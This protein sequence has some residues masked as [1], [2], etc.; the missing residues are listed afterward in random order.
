ENDKLEQFTQDLSD[1]SL[2][3]CPFVR[4]RCSSIAPIPLTSTP[5]KD[6]SL[7]SLNSPGSKGDTTIS[8][9]SS[10]SSTSTSSSSSI[11]SCSET[12]EK[13]LATQ[14]LS[15][16]T[17]D[18][19]DTTSS[20]SST[21]NMSEYIEDHFID[22]D[23]ITS[24]ERSSLE[25]TIF[26]KSNSYKPQKRLLFPGVLNRLIF[27]RRFFSESDLQRKQFSMNENENQ[28]H[29]YHSNTINEHSVEVHLINTYGSDTELHVWSHDCAE[30]RRF[31]NERQHYQH[32]EN[33]IE[34]K[35]F[36]H[37]DHQLAVE[38]QILLQQIFEY[39]WLL[40]ENDLDRTTGLSQI[41]TE[42]SL[43][44]PADNVIVP[45]HNPDFYQL[46][47]LT[48]SSSFVLSHD[49]NIKHTTASTT[50]SFV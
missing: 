1:G 31:L 28:F 22:Q 3:L 50:S 30:Q 11:F 41:N 37:D 20:A 7:D 21:F 23:D 24:D 32:L 6:I 4:N 15:N 45:S 48:N 16:I 18:I 39:P 19:A 8:S 40:Q 46:C 9:S 25:T 42:Q 29:V 38:R 26:D 13:I 35:Q 36:N 34:E 10:S 12:F 33:P 17:D 47:A 44:S 2:V 14:T 49:T 27:F 5:T 43:I